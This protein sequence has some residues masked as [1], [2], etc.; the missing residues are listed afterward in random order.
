MKSIVEKYAHLLVHYCLEVQ[1][2]DRV[3]IRTTTLAEPLVRHIYR[4]VLQAGAAMDVHFDFRE[5][6]RILFTEG[7]DF[8]L[9]HVSPLYQV[10][11]EEYNCFLNIRAPYNIHE[12]QG[13]H[14]DKLKAYQESMAPLSQ[15]YAERTA[16]RELRRSLCQYPTQAAAQ[17]AGMSLEDYENFVYNAC[18][19]FD[20]D[21]IESWKALGRRQEAI[22]G[23]LN[24]RER[25]HYLSE[26]VDI[27]FSTKGRTWI[28]SDGKTNMPSGEVYTS[29]VEDSVQGQIHFS[30]PG[31]FRGHTVEDVV[32]HVKDGYIEKWEAARGKAFLDEI[33]EVPGARRFG[34]AAIGTNYDIDQ[35]TRNILFDEK[36]G[37]T[38]HMAIGQSYLQAGGEN[39]SAVH[40]D[41]ITDMKKSGAIFADGEKIY[42]K[43]QFLP[44]ITQNF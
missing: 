25:I 33:F 10:A 26:G 29:P 28:N 7:S 31:I 37:G 11:L 4:Y 44:Q 8:A 1:P 14:P 17:N 24:Q 42:E 2:G 34:E 13:S 3:F 41:M 6:R 19:L 22:V 12:D 27:Q 39:T 18:K 21:P 20:D 16:T 35:L 9:Q 43:G 40:W 36:I 32:L 5:N 23:F 15:I 38:V 30:Y